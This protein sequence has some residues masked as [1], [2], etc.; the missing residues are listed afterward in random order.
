MRQAV[1]NNEEM[2]KNRKLTSN[3]KEIMDFI[4]EISSNKMILIQEGMYKHYN[5]K[6]FQFSVL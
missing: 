3:K 1:D 2:Q 5:T 6:Y 4:Q